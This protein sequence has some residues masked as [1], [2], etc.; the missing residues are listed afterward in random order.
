MKN[1]GL[2]QS[3]DESYMKFSI[4]FWHFTH[5]VFPFFVRQDEIWT[6]AIIEMNGFH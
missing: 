4:V 2:Y 1:S 5:G 3:S 6:L